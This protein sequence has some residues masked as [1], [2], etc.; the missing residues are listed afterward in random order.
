MGQSRSSLLPLHSL[1]EDNPMDLAPLATLI[2]RRMQPLVRISTP[3]S[4]RSRM[5]WDCSAMAYWAM[6]V[7]TQK[8]TPSFTFRPCM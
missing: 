2:V 6:L 7:N 3:Q 5:M 4:F 1:K 8:R